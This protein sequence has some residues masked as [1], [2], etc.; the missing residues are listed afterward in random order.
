MNPK[1]KIELKSLSLTL[2]NA[3]ATV[4]L[5]TVN[6]KSIEED[7]RMLLSLT[8]SVRNKNFSFVNN[9]IN[10][11]GKAPIII[12]PVVGSIELKVDG[13]FEIYSLNPDGSRKKKLESYKNKKGNTV[14]Y[15][16]NFSYAD[17]TRSINFE[18]LRK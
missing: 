5:T 17:D 2:D 11:P 3:W 6:G 12:Q 13:N 8:A 14:F 16:N 9:G 4:M 7:D 15:V 1:E 18:I 10:N